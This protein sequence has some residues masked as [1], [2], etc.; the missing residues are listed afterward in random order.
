MRI[1]PNPGSAMCRNEP[2]QAAMRRRAGVLQFLRCA[3]A[4]PPRTCCR[5]CRKD[6][7]GGW[8]RRLNRA[9]WKREA[10]K[11]RTGQRPCYHPHIS[12]Q[13]SNSKADRWIYYFLVRQDVVL[14]P[15]MEKYG[16]LFRKGIKIVRAPL[17]F[18]KIGFVRFEARKLGGVHKQE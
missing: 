5:V 1:P 15:A 11:R 9:P 16:N 4:S 2:K 8:Q 6:R 14:V 17:L 7:F 18:Q 13:L 10:Y 12:R 3:K